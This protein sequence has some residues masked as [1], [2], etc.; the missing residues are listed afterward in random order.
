MW[1]WRKPRRSP[2]STRRG[3]APRAA[4]AIS[5]LPFAQLGRDVRQAERAVEALFVGRGDELAAL[6]E[7]G[8]GEREPARRRVRRQLAQ[9]LLAAGGLHQHGAHVHRRRH[10]DLRA[11]AAGEAE[12][13]P[14][15]VLPGELVHAGML[16][17]PLEELGRGDVGDQDQH[18]VA[19]DFGAAA[20]VAGDDRGGHAGEPRQRGAQAFGLLGR[21]VG[22]P[23]ARSPGAGRRCS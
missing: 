3:S 20:H 10:H 8:A 2:R 18:Q 1:Q 6:P 23:V 19:H 14:A 15:L 13:E 21:V 7:R 17:Q 16:A 5:P 12:R 9:V 11:R 4:A 22:E